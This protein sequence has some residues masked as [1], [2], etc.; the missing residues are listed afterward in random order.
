MVKSKTQFVC[1]ECGYASGKWAGKCPSCENWNT[2]VEEVVEVVSAGKQRAAAI[3]ARI[4]T[5]DKIPAESEKRFRTGIEE[6]D[7]VLGGGVVPGGVTLAGGEPGIG[8]STLFL[9]VAKKLT[10]YGNVLYV[11][12][13]ESPSQIKLRAQRLNVAENIYLMAETEVGS[14]LAGVE[15]LAPKFLIVDSIQTLYDANLSSAPGSVAQVR[16]CASRVT[17]AAKRMGMAVFIVGH[18]TKEGALAGPR[19]LEHLVDTVLYFEGERTSNL[20]ILRA[21]KNRFGSTDEIGVFEMRDVGMVEVKNPTMLF[22]ADFHQEL[23]GVSIFAATQGTRPMLLEIQALCAHTQLNIPRRLCSGIDANR[24]YMICAVLEKKIGLKLYNEDIFVNVAGGIRVREHAADLSMAVSI[25]SS[26]R[27]L[28]VPRDMAF[29][30]E[31]GLSGEIRHVAQLSR[32][33]SEC[34]KMGIDTVF[35]PKQSMEKGMDA[36]INVV[37]VSTLSDVLAKAF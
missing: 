23:S 20:R 26:L 36:K 35:V 10:T 34:A 16:G 3:P 7:R 2:M 25:V 30:G 14:I 27:N 8:K 15:Q 24:L 22:E 18:V 1:S 28:S 4:V 37:G 6:F 12:G 17:Q 31:I 19:V 29:I 11:S 5:F 32:R 21:V 9:Q 33:I 13:E